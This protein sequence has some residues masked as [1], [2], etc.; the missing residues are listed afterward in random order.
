MYSS[1]HAAGII[2]SPIELE[3]LVPL[4]INKDNGGFVSCWDMK[5]IEELGLVKFDFLSFGKLSQTA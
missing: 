4:R 3:K 5:D 1:I 2:I